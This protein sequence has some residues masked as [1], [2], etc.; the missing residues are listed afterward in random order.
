MTDADT[1]PNGDDGDLRDSEVALMN[2]RLELV[3]M[4]R[5]RKRIRPRLPPAAG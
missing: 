5:S 2:A 3:L 1:S 4:V